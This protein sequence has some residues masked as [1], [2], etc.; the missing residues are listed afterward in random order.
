MPPS[1]VGHLKVHFAKKREKTAKETK[2]QKRKQN[3]LGHC[4]QNI[5][6]LKT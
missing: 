5:Q 1:H 3:Y 4:F 2:N 6:L